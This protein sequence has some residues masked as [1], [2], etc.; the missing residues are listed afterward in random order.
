MEAGDQVAVTCPAC[1]PRVETVHEVLSPGGQATVRCQACDHV[2]SQRIESDVPERSV[3]TVIS[4]AG[5]SITT[6]VDIPEDAVLEVGDRFVADTDEAVFSVELT[7]IEDADGGRHDRLT[8]GEAATLWTRDI[9]N[10]AVNVTVHP[11]PGS[12]DASTSAV[13]SVPGDDWVAVGDELRIDGTDV[14]VTGLLLRSSATSEG[15]SRTLDEPG[16]RAQ[17]M[18]LDRVYTRS[19]KRVRR[20]PW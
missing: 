20:D 8:A 14:R 17:A 3:R 1:S 2:H 19:T 11:A 6:T 5:E 16:D 13:L 15:G 9:G 7:D 4:Q 18:D 12:D 10:V